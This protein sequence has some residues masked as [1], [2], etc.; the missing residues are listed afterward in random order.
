MV[1]KILPMIDNT[2]SHEF[3]RLNFNLKAK[4]CVPKFKE[5]LAEINSTI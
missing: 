4:V 3:E 1:G 5:M 2:I